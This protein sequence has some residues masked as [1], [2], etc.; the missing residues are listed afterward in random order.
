LVLCR[1]P[2]L[3][4]E[5]PWRSELASGRLCWPLMPVPVDKLLVV[6]FSRL[7]VLSKP[8]PSGCCWMLLPL[9]HTAHIWPRLCTKRPKRHLLLL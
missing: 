1:P 6:R 4:I 7:A 5:A 2:A 3:L 8:S 9:L